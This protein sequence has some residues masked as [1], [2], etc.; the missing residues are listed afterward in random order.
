MQ[1]ARCETRRCLHLA[2]GRSKH[3]T[4]ITFLELDN[5][6]HTIHRDF[7]G[8]ATIFITVTEHKPAPN[9]GGPQ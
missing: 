1:L 2:P 5:I 3:E 6:Y 4:N 7:S 9:H 8:M